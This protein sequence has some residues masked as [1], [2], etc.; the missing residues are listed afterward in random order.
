[1]KLAREFDGGFGGFGT[2]GSEIDAAVCEIGR[3]KSEQAR[4]EFFGRGR[5]KLRGVDKS[6][7]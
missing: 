3:S 1:M 7:L 4:R 2:A 6:N 5:M